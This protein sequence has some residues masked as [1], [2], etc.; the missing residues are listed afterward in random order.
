MGASEANSKGKHIQVPN[1]SVHRLSVMP[2]VI[3]QP[4]TEMKQ[5]KSSNA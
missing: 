1:E 4:D 5:V 2:S 3:D